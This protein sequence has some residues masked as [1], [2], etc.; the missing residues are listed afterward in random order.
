MHTRLILMMALMLLLSACKKEEAKEHPLT[1]TQ[2]V[3][4]CS[5]LPNFA[6]SKR[7]VDDEQQPNIAGR[8]RWLKADDTP[9]LRMDLISTKNL[10]LA[11]PMTSQAWFDKVLPEIKASGRED[12]AEPKGPWLKAAITRKENEQELLFEDNGI[13]VVM[14]SSALDRATLLKFAEQTAKT[15]REAK[16]PADPAKQKWTPATSP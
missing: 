7:C 11:E 3:S 12:W 8:S 2:A 13:V 10:S 4:L 16:A 6:D 15:L 9:V 5:L 14:Q 1:Q